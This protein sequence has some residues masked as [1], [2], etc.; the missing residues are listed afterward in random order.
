MVKSSWE[1]FSSTIICLIGKAGAQ[2]EEAETEEHVRM[3]WTSLNRGM[4]QVSQWQTK[5]GCVTVVLLALKDNLH[6]MIF[7]IR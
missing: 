5:S 2:R 3:K 1:L 4:A 7:S 6:Y